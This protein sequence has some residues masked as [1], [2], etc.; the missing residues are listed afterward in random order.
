MRT[1]EIIKELI[2]EQLSLILPDGITINGGVGKKD[3]D[4]DNALYKKKEEKL[5]KYIRE[6]IRKELINNY[7]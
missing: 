6:L 7:K 4:E 5:R 2:K 1:I 3:E